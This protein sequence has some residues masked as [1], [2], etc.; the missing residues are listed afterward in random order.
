[1]L[2]Q[3]QYREKKFTK[4]SELISCLLV[5]RKNNEQL[6][7]NHQARPTSVAV[8][9]EVNAVDNHRHNKSGRGRNNERG[10]G[11][12]KYHR[13][14]N[15]H[16]KNGRNNEQALNVEHVCYR[17]GGKCH[18]SRTPKHLGEPYMKF[19]L[20]SEVHLTNKSDPGREA[21]CD[22]RGQ[23]QLGSDRQCDKARTKSGS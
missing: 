9:P 21:I 18:W 12:R 5:V 8:V 7:K 13:P 1:M 11:R 17:C 23:E 4:Y 3:Q 10:H 16:Q 2:M 14:K 6:M 15:T 22:A 19:R 20:K